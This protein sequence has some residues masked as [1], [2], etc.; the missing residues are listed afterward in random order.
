[1]GLNGREFQPITTATI[2]DSLDFD[3]FAGKYLVG[4]NPYFHGVIAHAFS[5]AATAHKEQ[6]RDSGEP[7]FA[8]PLMCTIYLIE[9]GFTNPSFITA[10]LLHDVKEDSLKYLLDAEARLDEVRD[11]NR[12]A[13]PTLTSDEYWD[14]YW[15]GNEDQIGRNELIADLFGNETAELVNAVSKKSTQGLSRIPKDRAEQIYIKHLG[16]RPPGAGIVKGVDRLHNLRTLPPDNP[17]RISRKIAE[18]K[19]GYLPIFEKAAK[20]YPGPGERLLWLI[21]QELE[22]LKSGL[23]LPTKLC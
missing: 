8:H 10:T 4:I 5:I 9:T 22:T 7:Y 6:P 12:A 18:T 19:E 14:E 11:L 13:E 23:K 20:E 16:K 3:P 17:K 1:M 15:K 2:P 21:E